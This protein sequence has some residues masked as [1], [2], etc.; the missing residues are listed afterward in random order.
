MTIRGDLHVK[1]PGVKQLMASGVALFGIPLV[2]L[3]PG[4]FGYTQK[5]LS[6]QVIRVSGASRLIT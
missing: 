1:S 6:E 4:L 5:L 3:F 2:I